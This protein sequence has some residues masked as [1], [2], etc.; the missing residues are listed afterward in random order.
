MKRKYLQYNRVIIKENSQLRV[1]AEEL[2]AQLS[3]L[4]AENLELGRANI[5][6][7]KELSQERAANKRRGNGKAAQQADAAVRQSHLHLSYFRDTS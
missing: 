6:L 3:Q 5:A 4:F 2:K 1:Q 7:Q